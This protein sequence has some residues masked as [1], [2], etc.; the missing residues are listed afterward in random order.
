MGC[1][2]RHVGPAPAEV[3]PAEVDPAEIHTAFAVLLPPG[4]PASDA[5]PQSGD[6]LVLGHLRAPSRLAGTI[7]RWRGRRPLRPKAAAGV[8]PSVAHRTLVMQTAV[9]PACR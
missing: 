3:D 2:S 4:V 7:A 8:Q 5:L 1:L 6:I 9:N